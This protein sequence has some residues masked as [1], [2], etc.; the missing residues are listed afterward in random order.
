VPGET[1]ENNGAGIHHREARYSPFEAAQKISVYRPRASPTMSEDTNESTSSLASVA[2]MSPSL[3]PDGPMTDLFGQALA[4]AN[5]S[6]VPASRKGSMT[7]DTCGP[8]GHL[9]SASARPATILGE[10]VAAAIRGGWLDLVFADLEAEGYACAAA[11][12]PAASVGAPHIRQRES[13]GSWPT[14]R[15][16]KLR[17]YGNAIVPQ[18]AAE[19]IGAFMEVRP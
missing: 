2:G 4:P 10:Q 13:F 12:L 14:R 1:E 3:S 16:S 15:P 5:H 6:A 9:S 11:V 19:V 18:A 8:L 17:A 7:N